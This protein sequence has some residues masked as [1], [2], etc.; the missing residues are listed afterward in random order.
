MLELLWGS[1][2]TWAQR[3][4][5]EVHEAGYLAECMDRVHGVGER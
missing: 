2:S 1:S 5:G 4:Q 3:D